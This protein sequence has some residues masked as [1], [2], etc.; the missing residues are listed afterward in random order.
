[1]LADAEARVFNVHPM[2]FPGQHL[3]EFRRNQLNILLENCEIGIII[4]GE[5]IVLP[6]QSKSKPS[7]GKVGHPQVVQAQGAA[8]TSS[9][10]CCLLASPCAK[11]ERRIPLVSLTLRLTQGVREGKA[12]VEP[13]PRL[14]S[15]GAADG[16]CIATLITALDRCRLPSIPS[17]LEKLLALFGLRMVQAG[18]GHWR[19]QDRR[20]RVWVFWAHAT[21]MATFVGL[22]AAGLKQL[23]LHTGRNRCAPPTSR[24][25]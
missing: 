10:S 6:N 22:L 18:V 25:L 7:M 12:N 3:R 4:C 2:S 8:A 21:P 23:H 13:A 24:P 20:L 19:T 15:E 16:Q 1:M 9:R 5:Q 14:H 17:P 11:R